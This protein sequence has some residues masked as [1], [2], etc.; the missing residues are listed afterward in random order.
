M[1]PP[2][3]LYPKSIWTSEKS[4]RAQIKL[5]D[6]K[7]FGV[8]QASNG[9]ASRITVDYREYLNQLKRNP[10]D[11]SKIKTLDQLFALICYE[12]I[13]VGLVFP[14][15][16]LRSRLGVVTARAGFQHLTQALLKERISF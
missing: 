6:D 10:K 9:K 11:L 15:R 3:T 2:K 13:E 14:P 16:N 8:V 1:A 7:I 4:L 5:V 12:M